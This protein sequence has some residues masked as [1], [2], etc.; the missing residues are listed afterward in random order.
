MKRLNL[1]LIPCASASDFYKKFRKRLLFHTLLETAKLAIVG[2]IALFLSLL[3]FSPNAQTVSIPNMIFEKMSLILGESESGNLDSHKVM[4]LAGMIEKITDS[5]VSP[6]RAFRYAALI[7]HA[8]QKYEVNPLE[9]IAV[10]MAESSFKADSMNKKTGDYGLGQINWEHWGKPFGLTCQE[11]LDPPINIFLTCHIYKYFG[12]DCGKYNRGNGIRN[13]TYIV[14]VK[15]ILSTLNAMG[16]L[17]KK[18]MI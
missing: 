11:L 4:S 18:K 8:S 5:Q 7:Y 10:I 9:I 15:S 6:S 3:Y 16:E 13:E 17:G 12:E 2:A 1:L 14:N